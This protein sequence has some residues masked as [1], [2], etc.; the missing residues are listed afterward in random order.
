RK[1]DR[2]TLR[3]IASW[4]D[5]LHG[6][7]NIQPGQSGMAG[8]RRSSS[9]YRSTD[10]RAAVKDFPQ[11]EEKEAFRTTL[12][13]SPSVRCQYSCAQGL[14]AIGA[15]NAHQRKSVSRK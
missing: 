2:Q 10:P 8:L 12:Q 5:P 3:I 13:I 7:R 14:S 15:A 1:T 6:G 9:H 4:P 11:A